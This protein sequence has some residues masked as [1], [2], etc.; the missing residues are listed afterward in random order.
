VVD[1]R[2]SNNE[3]TRLLPMKRFT[4]QENKLALFAETDFEKRLLKS[5]FQN[6]QNTSNELCFNNFAYSMRELCRNILDRLSPEPN[7]LNTSWYEN[8]VQGKTNGVTRAQRIRYAVHGG[9]LQDFVQDDLSLDLNP[10]LRRLIKSID[11]L[12]K[13]T[14]VSEET[15]GMP[16]KEIY[17]NVD[18]TV[19]TFVTFFETI[20]ACRARLI[21]KIEKSI[22]DTVL[23]HSLETTFDEIDMLS[24]QSS[25]NEVYVSR[26][27]VTEINDQQ[28]LISV[29]GT[30]SVRL[31]YGS[32]S[33]NRN[34]DG[35]IAYDS[36]PFTCDMFGDVNQLEEFCPE[37]DSMS[38]NT[39]SFY[40]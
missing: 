6:L 8:E 36:Y 7:I 11:L 24:T 18:N 28:I 30:I 23:N 1:S 2:R 27:S 20:K 3:A 4:K 39:R 15:L 12:N 16:L 26:V 17:R 33:D 37:V 22:D 40:E 5:A 35:Y 25:V 10:M 34:G 29:S 19:D 14:H 31:Q 13:Y 9:L 21:R 32:N 38:V